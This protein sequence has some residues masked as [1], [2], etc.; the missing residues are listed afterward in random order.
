MNW[1][2]RRFWPYAAGAALGGAYVVFKLVAAQAGG[3][4][5]D[6]SV[7]TLVEQA[8]AKLAPETDCMTRAKIKP[9]RT[10]DP[11]PEIS[12]ADFP[13]VFAEEAFVKWTS[14]DAVITT[15]LIGDGMIEVHQGGYPQSLVDPG[16]PGALYAVDSYEKAQAMFAD[17]AAHGALVDLTDKGRQA[18]VWKDDNFCMTGNWQ[19]A[20]IAKWSP[21]ALDST[22]LTV[23]HITADL[24][25]VP[26]LIGSAPTNDPLNAVMTDTVELVAA[27]YSDGWRIGD[28]NL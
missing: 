15:L 8:L 22:G 23:S 6:A 7:K 20:N 1:W 3:E 9:Y 19:V 5:S 2:I 13:V 10:N 26:S 11:M 28:I 14:A 16:T 27:K 17:I 4:L 24:D 18:H 12:E 25:L 21:P